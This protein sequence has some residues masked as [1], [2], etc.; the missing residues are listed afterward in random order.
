MN[1]QIHQ[2]PPLPSSLNPAV[3]PEVEAVLLRALAKAPAARYQSAGELI[4]ALCD[5]I[6]RDRH[7]LPGL[8]LGGTVEF[9]MPRERQAQLIGPLLDP[10][11]VGRKIH[12]PGDGA[13]S[14]RG[15]VG[16]GRIEQERHRTVGVLG[17]GREA[18]V[19]YAT[20]P[21]MR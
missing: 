7:K 9:Q 11:G 1:A 5:A 10:A 15:E 16:P 21:A 13:V 6:Q 3:S 2:P 20:R 14:H 12:R 19:H 4:A 8:R 18:R 17:G